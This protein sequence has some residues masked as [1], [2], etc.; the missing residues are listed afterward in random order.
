MNPPPVD[1][2]PV[3]TA[4]EI[5]EILKRIDLFEML[6]DEELE[7]VI[8]TGELRRFEQG[9]SLSLEIRLSISSLPSGSRPAIGSSRKIS[10]GSCTMAW[11]SSA[12]C[13][14]PVEKSPRLSLIHI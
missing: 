11:A 7:R 10:S 3:P 14:M 4:E 12:R 8:D 1:Q 13:R 5:L 9:E 2:H 6:S